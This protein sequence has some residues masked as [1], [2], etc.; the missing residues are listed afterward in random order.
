MAS[1][2]YLLCA[3]TSLLCTVLL[4]RAYAGSRLPLLYWSF[5]CFAGLSAANALTFIDLVVF[6]AVDLSIYRSGITLCS[7]LV[8]LY[9]LILKADI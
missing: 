9:A 3:L 1:T 8:L 4:G 2:V 5:L 7:I 6:P